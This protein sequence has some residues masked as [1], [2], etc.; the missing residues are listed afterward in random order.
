MSLPRTHSDWQLACAELELAYYALALLPIAYIFYTQG[1]SALRAWICLGLY[2]GLQIAGNAIVAAA[3]PDG[4]YSYIGPLLASVGLS[5]LLI[6][7]AGIL[8]QWFA[9]IRFFRSS[10]SG[11]SKRTQVVGIVFHVGATIAVA[12]IAAGASLAAQNSPPAYAPTLLRIGAI[13]LFAM[14]LVLCGITVWLPFLY[15]RDSSKALIW[16]V[17]I[18]LPALAVRYVCELFSSFSSSLDFNPIYG[19]IVF[20]VVLE[21]IP[22][23]FVLLVLIVGAIVHVEDEIKH[24]ILIDRT[25]T[26]PLRD[27]DEEEGRASEASMW[28]VLK[29]FG[30]AFDCAPRRSAQNFIYIHTF[31]LKYRSTFRPPHALANVKLVCK[32]IRDELS[33]EITNA[34]KTQATALLVDMKKVGNN[35]PLIVSPE[36]F[37]YP[38]R[39]LDAAVLGGF[40]AVT[41]VTPF[42][43]QEDYPEPD[44]PFW[45]KKGMAYRNDYESVGGHDCWYGRFR[46]TKRS[47]EQGTSTW[48]LNAVEGDLLRDSEDV[49]ID[50][51]EHELKLAAAK[52]HVDRM[53]VEKQHDG[54][55][56]EDI[57]AALQSPFR[58]MDCKGERFAILGGISPFLEFDHYER[59][60]FQHSYFAVLCELAESRDSAYK[61]TYYL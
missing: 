33:E 8:H 29:N 44:D 7:T 35:A 9:T 26:I 21:V 56:L 12:L 37:R 17:I 51:V 54:D 39:R 16:A 32:Q 40:A 57:L 45:K 31:A 52:K 41:F 1:R 28:L 58:W 46:Y 30:T 61:K 11:L 49:K 22:Q 43:T 20:R 27:A 4:E 38:I 23:L 53:V 24:D 18:S 48:T 25:A 47:N 34:K 10:Q 13:V 6:G 50:V 5:P 15:M 19:K 36:F 60:G 14:F 55:P 59:D 2:T 3:G 42:I